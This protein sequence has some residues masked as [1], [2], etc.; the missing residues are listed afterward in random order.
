MVKTNLAQGLFRISAVLYA[1]NNSV[2]ISTKQ[3]I[4]KIVEDVLFNKVNER[5]CSLSELLTLVEKEHNILLSDDEV[6]D[7]VKDKKYENDFLLKKDEDV[8]C[9]SR[10]LQPTCILFFDTRTGLVA[11]QRKENINLKF[12]TISF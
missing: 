4:R 1:R 11:I 10:I 12:C 5:Y 3:I 2:H 9:I 6:L 8:V 7:I